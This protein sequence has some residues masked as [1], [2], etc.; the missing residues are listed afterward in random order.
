MLIN[1]YGRL[2]R[3]VV[4]KDRYFQREVGLPVVLNVMIVGLELPIGRVGGININQVI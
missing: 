4:K 2:V 1:I 3:G